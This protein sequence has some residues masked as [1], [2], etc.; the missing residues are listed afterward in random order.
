[1][2]HFPSGCSFALIGSGLL[3]AGTADLARGQVVRSE[4]A[5]N[6]LARPVV[7]ASPPG[8]ARRLFIGE[9]HTGNVRI[10]DLVTDELQGSPAFL[11]IPDLA[12]GGEQGLLGLAFHPEFAQ[13][14]FFYVNLTRTDG[15]DGHPPLPGLAGDP[16]RADPQGLDLLVIAQPAANHNGG[17]LG[18]GPSDGYLVH[19]DRR[20]RRGA[21][22]A[23]PA[24]PSPA[25]TRRT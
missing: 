11:T 22:T 5:V 3:L 7:I 4:Q 17:W 1:M 15:D 9:Q 13:N 2:R 14:G 6:G 10:L 12:R 20:R 24:T 23:A 21:T 18:F 25:A 8:D 16:N 19:R